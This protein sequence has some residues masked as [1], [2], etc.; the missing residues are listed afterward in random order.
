PP[1][2]LAP[3][4]EVVP[5]QV[6]MDG[7]R[8]GDEEKGVQGGG[9]VQDAVIRRGEEP[10][11][12]RK[13]EDVHHLGQHVP[14]GVDAGIPDDQESRELEE[15]FHWAARSGSPGSLTGAPRS[16]SRRKREALKSSLFLKYFAR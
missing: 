2:L 9:V 4:F 12:D 6:G 10:G 14:Q 5:Q 7:E 1:L 3:A 15:R 16:S 11:E 8:S 13:E